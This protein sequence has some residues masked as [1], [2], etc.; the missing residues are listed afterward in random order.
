M[1][2]CH[3]DV[4]RATGEKCEFVSKKRQLL[5]TISRI[6][7]TG[8]KFCL[9]RPNNGMLR[10]LGIDNVTITLITAVHRKCLG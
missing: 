4:F 10:S 2:G 3:D 1:C 9:F 6:S 8:R 7:P 5:E